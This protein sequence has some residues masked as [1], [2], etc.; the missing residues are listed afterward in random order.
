MKFHAG[1]GA[2]RSGHAEYDIGQTNEGI[3][4]QFQNR[5]YATEAMLALMARVF[6]DPRV[7]SITAET[8]PDLKPSIRIMEKCGM[9]FVG[10]GSEP[11]VIRYR[12]A[13]H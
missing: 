4:D 10:P 2:M 3:L 6:E 5:G 12:K 9:S 11:G 8:L 7:T 1:W 13:R